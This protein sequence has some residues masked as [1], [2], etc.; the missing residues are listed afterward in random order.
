MLLLGLLFAAFGL[1]AVQDFLRPG[2]T[3]GHDIQHHA[4]AYWSLWRCVLDG[5]FW[6]R[7]NPYLALGIPLLSFYGPVG[8]V[9]GWPAQALGASPLQAM[10]WVLV[11]FQAL[12]AAGAYA[13]VRWL[14]GSVAGGLVA[15]FALCFAPYH[16]LDQNFRLALGET[17]AFSLFIPVFA[18]GWKLAQGERGWASW[19]L[20]AAMS[21]MLLTHVM[22]VIMA[23]LGLVL[24]S[25]LSW[26]VLATRRQSVLGGLRPLVLIGVLS[27]GATAAWWLPVA[28]EQEHTSV[29]RL[30]RPGRAI[31]PYAVTAGEVLRRQ[32]WVT[33]GSRRSLRKLWRL[34]A[35]HNAEPSDISRAAIES[36]RIKRRGMPMYF[37]WGMALLLFFG[38][39][40]RSREQSGEDGSATAERLEQS[41][42]PQRSA[43][44][45]AIAGS[46][47]LLLSIWP[48][49]R[50]LDGMPLFGRIMFPWRLYAPATALVAL[51][52]GLAVDFWVGRRRIALLALLALLAVD[53]APFLGAAMRYPPAPAPG[54]FV[55]EAEGALASNVPRDRFVR[56]EDAPL[57]PSDYQGQLA[58]SRWVFSEY[59]GGPLWK[60]YGRLSSPP[61]KKESGYF[62]AEVRYSRTRRRQI[63][64][65]A[66]PV[67]QIRVAE[68]EWEGLPLDAWDLLPERITL[69]I[70]QDSSATSLRYKGAWFPGWEVRIDGG[71][72]R[73][74]EP[75]E[76]HLLETAFPV[77]TRLVEFRYA[78]WQPWDRPLGLGISLAT[79]L[80]LGFLWCRRL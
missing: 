2:V 1:V 67:A 76:E 66:Q 59:M 33:Y 55:F 10:T 11:L 40:A 37:G 56:I 72:W 34:E 7:W 80:L 73:G 68:G 16:L 60:R 41:V 77:G 51:A 8:Y 13:S 62:G 20:G 24:I 61:S 48:L 63:P 49:A 5:D 36:E 69:R 78:F 15:A 57:P 29:G 6:P 9:A 44:R 45:L 71:D 30:S 14:G 70:P 25:L 58:K 79:L 43:R 17:L 75:S 3:H 4:W 47:L 19:I 12:G 23:A 18:A 28:V 52:G 31:S 35:A 54:F 53:A 26:R 27:A 74:T 32:L 21:T 42:P 46:I 65:S 38:L 50:V 64:L 22:S 39:A